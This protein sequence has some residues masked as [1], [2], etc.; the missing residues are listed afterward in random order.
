M[1]DTFEKMDRMYHLQRYFYDVTR[2]YYLLGRD[3]LL[4]D[5]DVRPAKPFSRSDAERPEPHHPRKAPPDAFFFG[6]DASEDMLEMA[7]A[8]IDSARLRNITLAHGLAGDYYYVNTFEMTTDSTRSSS[9]TRS[10]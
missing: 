1:S 9:H 2:K 5:M 8:K 4:R 3:Q 6:L 10:R 7:E